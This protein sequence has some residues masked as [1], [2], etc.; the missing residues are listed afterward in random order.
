VLQ[1]LRAQRSNHRANSGHA[2]APRPTQPA[3]WACQHGRL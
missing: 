3:A 1:D 2:P